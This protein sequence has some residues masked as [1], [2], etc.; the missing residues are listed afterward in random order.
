[1]NPGPTV[2]ESRML[3][4]WLPS[5]PKV[6][7]NN[8]INQT[9]WP[10]VTKQLGAK[11]TSTHV[12]LQ[13]ALASLTWSNLP[14][15]VSYSS[16]V[17]SNI[18]AR[19]T[20]D[21]FWTWSPMYILRNCSKK[22]SRAS[23]SLLQPLCGS[24]ES[25]RSTSRNTLCHHTGLLQWATIILLKLK[26]FRLKPNNNNN[27]HLTAL[28]RFPGLPGWAG[29][30]KVKLIWIQL[31][32]QTVSGSGISWAICKSAPHSRQITMSAPRHSVFHRPDALLAA[33]RT[34][35]KHWRQAA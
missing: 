5:H 29:T 34:V 14:H 11:I 21:V 8:H 33:Q 28:F 18:N 23:S 27:T 4:Y 15:S 30:G 24:R 35:S 2:P 9:E 10:K 7:W 17:R 20:R 32:Q 13:S 3:T 22:L 26:N 31:K 6:C 19:L 12:R 25:V 16:S 1:M